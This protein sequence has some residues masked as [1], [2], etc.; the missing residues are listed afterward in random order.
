MLEEPGLL[1]R[2]G[3]GVPKVLSIEEH[4]DRLLEEYD[5][6]IHSKRNPWKHPV[7]Y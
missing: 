4:V 7:E 6:T 2:I 1:E 5:R 3:K